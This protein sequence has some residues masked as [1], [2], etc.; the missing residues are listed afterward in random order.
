MATVTIKC[1]IYCGASVDGFIARLD[2]DI[3][4]LHRPEYADAA[5]VGLT[6][7][8]FIATVD[9]IVMGRRSFEKALTFPQWPYQLPVIVLSTTLR[10]IPSH[11]RQTVRL[12]AGDPASILSEL[13]SQGYQHLY[14]DGGLTIHRFLQ[15]RLINEITV[16]YLPILLGGGVSLFGSTGVETALKLLMT[17]TSPSG[18][19]QVRYEVSA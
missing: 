13:A 17:A 3:E 16:T 10:E 7:D 5:Q 8:A 9:G 11:L 1:S 15:A 12:A 2:G 4:W 18:V 19:V 14:I 6:Y